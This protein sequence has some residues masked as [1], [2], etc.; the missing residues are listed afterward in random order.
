MLFLWISIPF[1]YKGSGTCG[2]EVMQNFFLCVY[3]YI[4]IYLFH[5]VYEMN[6]HAL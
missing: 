1:V 4:F 5:G 6:F 3:M 2:T